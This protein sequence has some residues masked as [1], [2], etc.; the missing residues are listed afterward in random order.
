[1]GGGPGSG[2][3][4]GA[5]AREGGSWSSSERGGGVRRRSWMGRKGRAARKGPGDPAPTVGWLH[6]QV[7]TPI[8]QAN[9]V[10]LIHVCSRVAST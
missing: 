10:R 6:F 9:S 2:L 8:R 5:L 1:M 4:W 7:L 3:G